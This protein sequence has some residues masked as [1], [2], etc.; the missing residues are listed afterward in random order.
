[1]KTFSDQFR[2]HLAGD[3]TTLCYCWR[4][5][6]RDGEVFGFT[7]HDRSINVDGTVFI[8]STGITT[9]RIVRR[10]GMSVDNLELQGAIDDDA[11]TTVDIER[12]LYDGAKVDLYVAN[13]SDPTQFDHLASGTFGNLGVGDEGFEVEFRSRSHKLNQPIGRVYQRTCNAKLGDARCKAVVPTVTA[14]IT[15]TEGHTVVLDALSEPNEWFTLGLLT[16]AAGARFA[17]KR[18]VGRTLTLWEQP[19]VP[20][21]GTVTLTPG[22]KQ[23][24]DTCRTKFNNVKNFR[25]FPFIPGN[26]RLTDYPVRGKDNY[27]GGSLFK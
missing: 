21:T 20:P 18:Q 22:C 7:D 16:D 12:G 26:D 10:L 14:Q 1:M 19:V 25:G 8:G 13:W 4:V 9:S 27:N 2:A 5:E 11:L 17:I 23:D 3:S 24:V 15:S 6:R